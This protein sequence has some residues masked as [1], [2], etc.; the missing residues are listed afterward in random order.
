M[1]RGLARIGSGRS[2]GSLGRKDGRM[3]LLEMV[4]VSNL[5]LLTTLTTP[6]PFMI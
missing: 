6:I 5:S 1:L 3:V 4:G 2:W